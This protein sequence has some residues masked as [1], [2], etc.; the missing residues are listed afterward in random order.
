MV[1]EDTVAVDANVVVSKDRD[2][3]LYTCEL[4]VTD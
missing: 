3:V 4:A 2:F 1:R